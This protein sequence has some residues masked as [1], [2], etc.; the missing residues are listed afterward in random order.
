M[1][2]FPN[3]MHRQPNRLFTFPIVYHYILKI[4]SLVKRI[5][6]FEV[7]RFGDEEGIGNGVDG[8]EVDGEAHGL[9]HSVRGSFGRGSFRRGHDVRGCG[10]RIALGNCSNH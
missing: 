3:I 8:G 5:R 2:E 6:S 1:H 10:A 7:F 4:A 9:V